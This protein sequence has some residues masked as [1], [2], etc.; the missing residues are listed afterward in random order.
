MHKNHRMKKLLL[1]LL[2]SFCFAASFAQNNVQTRTHL[3]DDNWRFKKDSNIHAE[4][5][6][7]NDD[8]WRLLQLPHDWSIED[9]PNQIAD[10]IVGPF[11][12][13]AVSLQ[14]GGFLVGGTAWYRKHFITPNATTGK[15]TLIQFDGVYMN[16][17]VWINGH[18]VGN[19]PHGYT[20]FYYDLT[21]YLKP[22]GQSNTIA[23]RVRNEGQNS[24][25]YSG[26]GIYRHVWLTTVDPT[27]IK[28][29]GTFITTPI[30]TPNSAE[31]KISTDLQK[32][33][34]IKTGLT[35]QVAIYN[36][37][38]K[39]VATDQKNI[40]AN[41]D[42]SLQI[43][44]SLKV[45]TPHLWSL[46]D[47][48]LYQATTSILQNGKILDVVKNKFGI[49]TIHFD[50]LN[51]FALNGKAI[52]LHGGC[53]HH[54]NGPL[55]S[56]AI[57]R[58]EE[59]KI[60]ILKKQGYNAIRLSHN[61]PSPQLLDACDKLGMLVIDEA[62]DMW[63]RSKTA[64]DYHL[65][66]NDWW[67]KDI[68]S[69]V[70]R[71]RNH[72]S[73]IMWSI[74]NEIPEVL[75]AT[76]Y[77]IGK[78]L[79][80][81]IRSLDTSRAITIAIPLF[82]PMLDKGK[83]WDDSAPSYANVDVGG[84]NYADQEYEKDHLKYPNRIMYASEYFPPKGMQN[85]K[86]VESLNY[87]IGSFS[88]SAMDYLGEAGLGVGR[89]A[90]SAGN[91][92]FG[93]TDFLSP[94]WP[95]FISGTGELDL[96]GNKKVNSYYLDVVWKRSPIEMLVH[97]PV[98]AGKKELNF[99]Y[100]FPDQIKSWTWNGM[101]S[102]NM[103]VYV[104]TRSAKVVL[105]LNGKIVGEQNLVTDNII[106]KFS[107]PYEPG[108]LI[109]KSYSNNQLTGSD[110]LRTAGKPAAI[111]LVADRNTIKTDRNDLSYISVEVVDEK[112]NWVPNMEGI[113]INYQI[114]GNANIAGVANG[115]PRDISSFQQNNKKVFHGKG[116]VI[117][118]PI[119]KAGIV[120]L[121]ASA[122]GVKEGLV[123]IEIKN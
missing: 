42:A 70:L 57:D 100:N 87:V 4:S 9:L 50:T 25:W 47:P 48:Y 90:T 76:G 34:T 30:V 77:Q 18:Y 118:R 112:G 69:M 91:Q 38:G 51:G 102:K 92:V 61:P 95:I 19:H 74:G 26:S 117:I 40:P 11:S 33:V 89:I 8:D 72:P 116:L 98:P 13:A 58:A 56:A 44:Q 122:S 93:S 121:K 71:D 73:I 6:D 85:W 29:W 53:I 106:A 54:D 68:S 105:E 82:A 10:S 104:Y 75:N 97:Q 22:F 109:A 35:I 103:E 16:A 101:E 31:V 2:L 120:Q 36:A 113:S 83:K 115:N 20:S 63:E 107:I 114:V 111:R 65:Y 79:S 37:L 45:A 28:T 5:S 41:S 81:T 84:Y 39:L 94:A 52:K 110:T 7:Y 17:D 27:H 14:A 59:R 119:G 108:N 15:Q 1:L 123:Q 62:F 67:Q 21:Q 66:F 23:V 96:I 88:W 80:A 46:E 55:G 3:F 99:L 24:R 60:E 64:A 43:S 32:P 86:K 12:K 78:N 49:R